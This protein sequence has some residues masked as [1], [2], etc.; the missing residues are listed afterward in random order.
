MVLIQ[1][2]VDEFSTNWQTDRQ[3]ADRTDGQTEKIK[4]QLTFFVF[5]F[6]LSDDLP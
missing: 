1:N 5:D 6:D 2:L 3:M 4:T